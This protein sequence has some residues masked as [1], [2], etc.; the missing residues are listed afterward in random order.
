MDLFTRYRTYFVM[1]VIFAFVS[2]FLFKYLEQTMTR[3]ETFS[4]DDNGWNNDTLPLTI[5]SEAAEP[6][7]YRNEPSEGIK[8]D[9]VDGTA[10]CPISKNGDR[11][12][13]FQ[14]VDRLEGFVN[15]VT[16]IL[17]NTPNLPI[18]KDPQ[19]K[20]KWSPLSKR[21]TIITWG[22]LKRLAAKTE[23][24]LDIANISF[25][26][27]IFF[28][29]A[30]GKTRPYTSIF[31]ISQQIS[32]PNQTT[33]PYLQDTSLAVLGWERRPV[34]RFVYMTDEHTL[35]TGNDFSNESDLYGGNQIGYNH[36]PS[37]IVITIQNNVIRLNMDGVEQN[38]FGSGYV[39]PPNDDYVLSS[40]ITFLPNNA[41]P[42]GI[43]VRDFHIYGE[44]LPTSHIQSMYNHTKNDILSARGW[45]QSKI[46]FLE[47]FTN[48]GNF[49]KQAIETFT[50]GSISMNN[51]NDF[52]AA[53]TVDQNDINR[54]DEYLKAYQRDFAQMVIES[55]QIAI[56]NPSFGF[57]DTKLRTLD[58]NSCYRDNGKTEPSNFQKPPQHDKYS[59]HKAELELKTTKTI[60]SRKLGYSYKTTTNSYDMTYQLNVVLKAIQDGRKVTVEDK[61]KL[62]PFK[63][64]I[65]LKNGW[66]TNYLNIPLT[67]E[68]KDNTT[69]TMV[70][71]PGEEKTFYK[72]MADAIRCYNK[73]DHVWDR[74]NDTCVEKEGNSGLTCGIS[75]PKCVNYVS[76]YK[77][78][79]CAVDKANNV[80]DRQLE[81]VQIEDFSMRNL[82]S[83]NLDASKDE[84]LEL[85]VDPD[86]ETDIMFSDQGTTISMWFKV[87]PERRKTTGEWCRILDFCNKEWVKTSDDILI[88]IDG[89]S[90]MGGKIIFGAK[91]SVSGSTAYDS[92]S[93]SQVMN[94][95][96]HHIAWV[97]TP[98]RAG[99][100]AHWIL[101]HNGKPLGI[102][103]R[104]Y[105]PK[106]VRNTKVIGGPAAVPWDHYWGP[107][108]ADFKIYKGILTHAQIWKLYSVNN[109]I[110]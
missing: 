55:K 37:F 103:D 8:K 61:Y 97:M 90:T 67:G 31:Q 20:H 75:A 4:S 86:K 9:N 70:F 96:W 7:T 63:L 44:Y 16:D 14:R 72:K 17:R 46:G 99:L 57:K 47:G 105:P 71:T 108:I 50:T 41:T 94:N 98:D 29:E 36:V 45:D 18:W 62:K 60:F 92:E 77:W 81:S 93:I 26:F 68:N 5:K 106:K 58:G 51:N 100:P 78:G 12:C 83:V 79:K 64:H 87:D 89:D 10:F 56:S 65:H 25:S 74:S 15:P 32:S 49:F 1:F 84:F 82:S 28:D 102:R 39:L 40:G 13:Q 38:T 110:E 33:N 53:A 11:S 6:T 22:E 30:L 54:Y 19:S 52:S 24:K 27:W 34:L 107:S 21:P 85:N 73:L 23:K 109:V 91:V 59:I 104:P 3:K 66:N 95:K 69:F 76:D 101:Y 88:A 35:K 2:F 43:S 48:G 80:F 42:V